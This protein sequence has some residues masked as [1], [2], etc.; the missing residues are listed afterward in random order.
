MEARGTVVV[1]GGAMGSATAWHLAR[2]GRDVTLLERYGARHDLGASH[3]RSRNFNVSYPEPEYQALVQEAGRWWR[4][5]ES[6]SGRRLLDVVGLVSHGGGVAPDADVA[7]RVVGARAELLDA[8]EAAERWAGIR[9]DTRVLHLPEGGRLDAEEAVVALQEQAAAHGAEVRL[10]TPVERLVPRADGRVEVVN[11][12]TTYLADVAVVTVGAWTGGLLGGHL[13]LPPLRVTQ[14]QPAHFGVA[15]PAAVWPGFM[16]LPADPAAPL[17]YGMLTPGEGIKAGWHGTGPEVDPDR[18][19]FRP[20]P[21]QLEALRRYVREWLPGADADVC[22]PIS[23]TYTTT[24]TGDFVLD[25]RGP[26]VVGAGFSGHGF[27]LCPR[28]DG[29][30][31]TSPTARDRRRACSRWSASRRWRAPPGP[32]RP[33]R[34]RAGRAR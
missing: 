2:R 27:T 9:F 8:G 29:C 16:H 1:G 30:S 33:A 11:A 4:E 24:P 22:A 6:A 31:P 34:R 7:L 17:V 3:G 14:E 32:A 18:R 19:S 13:D 23:C 21:A 20:E 26:L 5:L 12:G 25:R 15:D 10:E 28:S